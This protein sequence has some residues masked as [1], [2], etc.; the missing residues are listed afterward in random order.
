MGKSTM[1]LDITA[2]KEFAS[3]AQVL[4][5]TADDAVKCLKTLKN[6]LSEYD[7]QHGNHLLHTARLHMRSD[8]RHAKDVSADLKSVARQ[9][10][11]SHKP[12]KEGVASAR[13]AMNAVTLAMDV[14]I[15]TAQRYDEKHSHSSDVKGA[16]ESAVN[17][18]DEM[19]KDV[20]RDVFGNS[21]YQAGH[22]GGCVLSN[23]VT[24]EM[25]V[26]RTLSDNF[27][28]NVL[29]HQITAAEKSLSS[30]SIVERAKEAVNDVKEKLT[31]NSS[32][33]YAGHGMNQSVIS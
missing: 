18:K 7:S 9:I 13:T 3:L 11:E 12:S 32:P 15:V 20:Q 29:S 33:T 27:N 19:E 16:M 28:L 31:G 23:L 14:L 22:Q 8:I 17:G 21:N 25:V 30:Y 5:I 10:H 24:V 26:K 1:E 6:N 4:T 2:E